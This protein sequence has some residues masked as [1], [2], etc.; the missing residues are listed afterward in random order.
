MHAGHDAY[1]GHHGHGDHVAQFR[2]MF[3]IMLVIAVP[4]VGLSPMFAH[5]IG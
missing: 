5:L 3:W 1:A 2:R 4:V